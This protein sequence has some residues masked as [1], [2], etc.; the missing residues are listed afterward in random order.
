MLLGPLAFKPRDG[1]KVETSLLD[2]HIMHFLKKKIGLHNTK[3][4]Y[5]LFTGQNPF[6]VFDKSV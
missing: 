3:K 5:D 1:L 6:D 2:A 4:F